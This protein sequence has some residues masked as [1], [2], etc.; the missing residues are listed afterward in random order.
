MRYVATA[1]RLIAWL[2]EPEAAGARRSVSSVHKQAKQR[3]SRPGDKLSLSRL[4]RERR[5]NFGP[6]LARRR[7]HMSDSAQIAH[8]ND[9]DEATI[10][11]PHNA[12]PPPRDDS[13]R[14]ASTPAAPT[15]LHH[16]RPLAAP[17]DKEHAVAN[18]TLT[19]HH[20]RRHPF[21]SG[22][23]N[24]PGTDIGRDCVQL[25]P[26][27]TAAHAPARHHGPARLSRARR[28][29]DGIRCTVHMAEWRL[30]SPEHRAWSPPRQRC[31]RRPR[32]RHRHDTYC[33]ALFSSVATTH[34][35]NIQR[36]ASKGQQVQRQHHPP[37]AHHP[38]LARFL[39]VTF[40]AASAISRAALTNPISTK[41]AGAGG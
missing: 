4:P 29:A 5:S 24:E 20:L 25:A 37:P 27:T 18:A 28:R 14:R 35:E 22:A 1:T 30:V 26:A 38:L 34:G 32:G 6:G 10:S 2:G 16:A 7:R 13:A 41:L 23:G 11:P 19:Y 8:D 3:R 33:I 9:D 15:A 21:R 31:G 12:P 39:P 40:S 36:P 17:H